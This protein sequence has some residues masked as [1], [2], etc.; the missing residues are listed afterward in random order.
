M[1]GISP[2]PETDAA[3]QQ[4]LETEVATKGLEVMYAA[5]Q[6]FDP[7]WAAKI[8][9]KDHQRIV[10]GHLAYRQTKKTLTQWHKLPPKGALECD[11][12]CIAISPPRDVL[13]GR[14][15]NRFL[16]M[17]KDGVVDEAQKLYDKYINPPRNGQ[18]ISIAPSLTSIGLPVYADFFENKITLNEAHEA[19]EQQMRQYAKRQRTWLRNSY[20]KDAL[21]FENGADTENIVKSVLNK[22][23]S[24]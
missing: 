13:N 10:R 11:F 21:I 14:I 24:S 15:H 7:A 3:L 4:E 18:G 5:L 20:P 23:Q 12:V 22:L 9:P 19:V 17:I 8:T 6:K 1:E 2:M 16:Q